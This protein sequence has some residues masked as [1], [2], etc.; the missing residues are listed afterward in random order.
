[1]ALNAANPQPDAPKGDPRELP[2]CP[3]C[4]GKMETVYD[5]HHQKVCVCVDCRSG[6]TVPNSAWDVVRAKRAKP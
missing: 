5:R 4:Q 6:V 1:M 3:I 2:A